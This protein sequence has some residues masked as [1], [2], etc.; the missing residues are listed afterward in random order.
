[1]ATY[2]TTVCCILLLNV[3]HGVIPHLLLAI[4]MVTGVY[5]WCKGPPPPPMINPICYEGIRDKAFLKLNTSDLSL[6]SSL[7]MTHNRKLREVNDI[8]TC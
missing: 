8:L 1:M 5:L 4:A 7:A 3:P 6:V 2:I